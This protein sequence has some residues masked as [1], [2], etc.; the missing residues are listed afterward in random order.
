L[1]FTEV[2]VRYP[3]FAAQWFAGEL[4]SPPCGED[5]R[6]FRSRVEA[7][8][9]ELLLRRESWLAV[10]HLGVIRAA[11]SIYAVDEPWSEENLTG[12]CQVDAGWSVWPDAMRSE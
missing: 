8:L 3:E 6:E 5:V 4:A 7:V 2:R 10:T 12:L 1:S 11:A 9:G